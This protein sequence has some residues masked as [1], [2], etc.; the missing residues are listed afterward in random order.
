MSILDTNRWNS[1]VAVEEA[2]FCVCVCVCAEVHACGLCTFTYQY[3][4]RCFTDLD[5]SRILSHLCLVTLL[6]D[7]WAASGRSFPALPWKPLGACFSEIASDCLPFS[8]AFYQLLKSLGVSFLFSTRCIPFRTLVL[9]RKNMQKNMKKLYLPDQKVALFPQ[10][11]SVTRLR[12]LRGSWGRY[13]AAHW[14][15]F[16][17]AFWTNQKA[18]MKSW[19]Y[20]MFNDLNVHMNIYEMVKPLWLVQQERPD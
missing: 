1:H 13:L 10:W 6:Q 17:R 2:I 8:T 4:M 7:G 18:D 14:S 20:N 9:C 3:Y 11:W 12:S 15:A 16:A 5:G 19:N